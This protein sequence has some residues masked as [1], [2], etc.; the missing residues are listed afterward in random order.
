M[1]I[2]LLQRCSVLQNTVYIFFSKDLTKIN[3]FMLQWREF[4]LSLVQKHLYAL[5]SFGDTSATD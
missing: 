4:I 2:N 5:T 3:I 1:K